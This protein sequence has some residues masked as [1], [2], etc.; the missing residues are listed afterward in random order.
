M[1]ASKQLVFEELKI[2]FKFVDFKHKCD[3]CN[4]KFSKKHFMNLHMKRHNIDIEGLDEQRFRSLLDEVLPKGIK[5]PINNGVDFDRF[6]NFLSN[7]KHL[8]DIV[9][10]FKMF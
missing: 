8:D 10:I 4:R 7:Q 6:D 9:I 3:Y 2:F 5:F 1:H